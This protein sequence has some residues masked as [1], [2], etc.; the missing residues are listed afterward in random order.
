MLRRTF[1]FAALL[2]RFF[3]GRLGLLV[4]FASI[5]A[6][7]ALTFALF[8]SLF[9]R[10]CLRLLYRLRIPRFRHRRTLS[11]DRFWWWSRRCGR[12]LWH[13]RQLFRRRRHAPHNPV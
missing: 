5:V 8:G 4:F 6:L 1:A 13:P 2:D 9:L 12:R 10:L 11:L 3:G 7:I